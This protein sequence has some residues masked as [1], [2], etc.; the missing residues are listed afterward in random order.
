MQ[1]GRFNLEYSCLVGIDFTGNS[2]SARLKGLSGVRLARSKL[3]HADLSALVLIGTDFRG[4]NA[5][6]WHNE[7]WANDVG[8]KNINLHEMEGN[9]LRYKYLRR[10]YVTHF[11]SANLTDANFEGAGLEG[12]DF[13]RATLTNVIFSGA[14]I[15]RVNFSDAAV[16]PKQLL[17]ACVGNAGQP[18]N[19]NA[20]AQPILTPAQAKA[21]LAI[22]PE[23]IPICP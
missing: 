17:T 11:I 23:G 19:E 2:H 18:E 6:D 16:T 13:S 8:R 5:G 20:A 12:A 7:D 10:R 21:L 3:L 9:D 22:R 14:N 15:S 1:T 4:I